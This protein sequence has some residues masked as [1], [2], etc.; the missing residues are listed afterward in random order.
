MHTPYGGNKGHVWGCRR[1]GLP[2]NLAVA[3]LSNQEELQEHLRVTG[4]TPGVRQCCASHALSLSV[5]FFCSVVPIPHQSPALP[6]SMLAVTGVVRS[7][8]T[9]L[10]LGLPCKAD[11]VC[12]AVVFVNTSLMICTEIITNTHT[13]QWERNKHNLIVNFHWMNLENMIYK[14]WS[15]RFKN[16]NLN[17]SKPICNMNSIY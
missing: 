17:I 2:S 14:R 10:T 5:D 1:T 16:A 6:R 7:V 3:Y 9:G 13:A 11:C 8:Q 15:I 4:V 12:W